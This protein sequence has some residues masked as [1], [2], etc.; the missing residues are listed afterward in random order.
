MK[1]RNS[2]RIL[3]GV[4]A[5]GTVIVLGAALAAPANAEGAGSSNTSQPATS[6]ACQSQLATIA[7]SDPQFAIDHAGFCVG[8]VTTTNG[9]TQRETVAEAK[10]DTSGMNASAKS[11][12]VAAAAAGAIYYQN[13]SQS[14]ASAGV[15][16][17]KQTG[18]ILFDGTYAWQRTYRGYYG[19]HTCHA[20]GS[21]AIGYTITVDTS[22]CNDP[23]AAATATNTE[24]FDAT[25]FWK[26]FPVTTTIEMYSRYTAAGVHT[27]WQVGG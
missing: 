25:L 14:Y 21:F 17:E 2:V 26:G 19:S 5:A 24:R 1:Q 6:A 23:V 8:T 10:A 4:I 13:W 11:Q 7:K 18:K 9:V 22:S 3:G 12:I 20:A 27:A 16:L 15:I